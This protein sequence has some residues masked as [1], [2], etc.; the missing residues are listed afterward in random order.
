MSSKLVRYSE[1]EARAIAERLSRTETFKAILVELFLGADPVSVA[2]Q[3]TVCAHYI[4][5]DL[6]A[7]RAARKDSSKFEVKARSTLS[8]LKGGSS[9]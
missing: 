7:L 3:I 4:H 8:L 9:V 1:T 5:R 2:N 6:L